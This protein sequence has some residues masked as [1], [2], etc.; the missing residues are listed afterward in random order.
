[1]TTGDIEIGCAIPLPDGLDLDALETLSRGVLSDRGAD[2][3][4][5]LV[6]AQK[7]TPASIAIRCRRATKKRMS[8]S[9]RSSSDW[10]FKHTEASPQPATK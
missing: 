5:T 8:T 2:G 4:V 1:M 3:S 7:R 9:I 10:S 6:L